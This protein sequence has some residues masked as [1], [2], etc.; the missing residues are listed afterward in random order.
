MKPITRRDMFGKAALL[1]TTFAAS[2]PLI[3]SA[4]AEQTGSSETGPQKLK[5]IITGGHPGDPEYGCGGTGARYSDLGHDVILLYLN[6]GEGTDEASFARSAATRT[7]EA[8]KACEILKARPAFAGQIDAQA[9]VDNKHYDQFR[10]LIGSE[11][12]DIVF[13][14]WPIDNHRDHRAISLLTYDAWVRLGKK[15]ALYYYEVSNGED[16]VQFAPTHYV[17]IS[18]VAARKRQACFAHA[19]QSPE[20]FYELQELVMRM[21]GIE[22]GHKYAEGF[23]RHI[24]SPPALLPGVS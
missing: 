8:A 13:T 2:G 22:S 7:A 16:T 14:Q 24:Q 11:R 21:R 5:V 20:R 18:A 1:G 19:S 17:D 10:S 15:F 3:A 12:P 4:D 23:I 6:K 9:I